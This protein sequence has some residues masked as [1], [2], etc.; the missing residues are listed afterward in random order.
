MNKTTSQYLPPEGF[1][2]FSWSGGHAHY[3]YLWRWGPEFRKHAYIIL[4][5]FLRVEKIYM[6]KIQIDSLAMKGILFDMGHLAKA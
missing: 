5:Y 4:E 2:P 6:K 3:A 1:K